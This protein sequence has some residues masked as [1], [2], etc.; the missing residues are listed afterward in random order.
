MYS[1]WGRCTK[2]HLTP[3][4]LNTDVELVV[5]QADLHVSTMANFRV[6][7]AAIAG[8]ELVKAFREHDYALFKLNPRGP[9]QNKINTN[10]KRTI[11][12]P[13]KRKWFFHLNNG[14]TAVCETFRVT[15]GRI[16]IQG[17]PDSQRLS[18]YRDAVEDGTHR[19][20]GRRHQ[21]ATAAV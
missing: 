17:F 2:S 3:A 15:E 19:R 10:I 8:R 7:V 13:G 16:A 20:G 5:A 21:G 4:R 14:L 18:D 9:L 1:S 11:E 12:D 6:L